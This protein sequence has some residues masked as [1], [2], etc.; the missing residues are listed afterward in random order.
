MDD[1]ASARRLPADSKESNDEPSVCRCGHALERGSMIEHGMW[2]LPKRSQTKRVLIHAINHVGLGHLNRSIA[3]AQW[4]RAG[5]ANLQVLFLIEGGKDFIEQTGFPW[6][7]VPGQASESE[8]CEQ[9]TRKVLEVFCPDLTIYETL[10]REAVHRPTRE[11]GVKQVVMGSFGDVL[12]D[13]LRQNLAMLNTADLL[14]ILQRREEVTLEDQALVTHYKGKTVY[15][16]PLVR[17]KQQIST[18]DLRQKL[19]LTS[20]HKVILV[21]FGGGGW[22]TATVLLPRLLAT[23]EAL[24]KRFPQARIV[25]LSGPH[26]SGNLPQVDDFVCYVSRFEPFFTDYLNIASVVVCMAGYST[27]NEVAASGI[28]A[29]CVPASEADDQVGCGSMGEYAQSFPNFVLSEP[30]TEVL[31]HHLLN[32]LAQERDNAV[33]HGFWQRAQAASQQIIDEITLLL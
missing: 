2:F 16:G 12:R 9:I 6:I 14:L 17:K 32:A 15:A 24:L 11:A 33:I 30:N 25:L 31:A 27:V 19:G 22:D 7:L 1:L 28:P 10:I 29:I 8:H 21:T 3:V 26:F 23:K 4:L 20:E 18:H 5:I 13:Q